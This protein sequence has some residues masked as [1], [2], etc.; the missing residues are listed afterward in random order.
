MSHSNEQSQ[1]Q[2]SINQFAQNKSS[3]PIKTSDEFLT[4]FETLPY[5]KSPYFDSNYSAHELSKWS[6]FAIN[7][8]ITYTQE[9]SSHCRKTQNNQSF[10]TQEDVWQTI[11]QTI[12]HHTEKKPHLD[13]LPFIGGWLGYI[14][15]DY[16]FE[17]VPNI[18]TKPNQFPLFQFSLFST[19]VLYHHPTNDCFLITQKEDPIE[20]KIKEHINQL[21]SIEKP[22]YM[23]T[24]AQPSSSYETYA[25]KISAILEHIRNGDIYQANFTHNFIAKFQGEPF[26]L[27]KTLKKNNPAPF[28]AFYKIN[29]EQFILSSSPERLFSIK[30]NK[31]LAHPIKGTIQRGQTPEEDKTLKSELLNS[32]K[33]SAELAMI[34]D[35][36]RND[37]GRISK[38]NTVQVKAFKKLESFASVH[39]L[40]G[41]I[42]GELKAEATVK[43]I[44]TALFPGGSITG[45]PK[46]RSMQ[47]LSKLEETSRGPYTGS[48]GYIDVRGNMDF[49][50]MIRTILIHQNQ[51]SFQVGGG[52]I[53]DSNASD[54]YKE[55][56]AKT[57]TIHNTLNQ[58]K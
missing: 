13:E 8:I 58:F 33:N 25:E 30:N 42:E 18:I 37:I 35:L 4:L 27:Y 45:A 50:I 24:K 55:T 2:Y 53:S 3:L 10:L 21:S 56:L 38:F 16:P 36:I 44:F 48:L 22:F 14:S 34:V 54:E 43:D 15:Y 19:V 1:K 51:L 12:N 32:P 9:N 41:I 47:I 31:I 28:S 5:E 46:I 49:N 29:K 40:I 7:P 57:Q 17:N 20:Q 23:I 6:F 52:I 11:Q 39:H 26:T